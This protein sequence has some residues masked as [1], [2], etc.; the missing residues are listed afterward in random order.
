MFEGKVLILVLEPKDLDVFYLSEKTLHQQET[1]LVFFD[2]IVLQGP[3]KLKTSRC[4][5]GR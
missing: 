4:T 3:T 1:V 2:C 5:V